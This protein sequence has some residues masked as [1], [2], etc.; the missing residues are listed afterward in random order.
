MKITRRVKSR[1]VFLVGFDSLKLFRNV[2]TVYSFLQ[3]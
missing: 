2:D 1:G 3:Y